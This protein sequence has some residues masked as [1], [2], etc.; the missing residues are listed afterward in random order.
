MT[1]TKKDKRKRRKAT[2]KGKKKLPVVSNLKRATPAH[3]LLERQAVGTLIKN[4]ATAGLPVNQIA[5]EQYNQL[6]N[7]RDVYARHRRPDQF[8]LAGNQARQTLRNMVQPS[9]GGGRRETNVP[10]VPAVEVGNDG[11][12]EAQRVD[13]DL[14]DDLRDAFYEAEGP[15]QPP[16]AEEASIFDPGS[17][18]PVAF[19]EQLTIDKTVSLLQ[20]PQALQ[21]MEEKPW[22]KNMTPEQQERYLTSLLQIRGGKQEEEKNDSVVEDD[23]GEEEKADDEIDDSFDEE[24]DDYDEPSVIKQ[25]ETPGVETP[26]FSPEPFSTTPKKTVTFSDIP[27]TRVFAEVSPFSSSSTSSPGD[28]RQSYRNDLQEKEDRLTQ[29]YLSEL[30]PNE[31][32]LAYVNTSLFGTPGGRTA[33][34]SEIQDL[35]NDMDD[36]PMDL[37][38][39]PDEEQQIYE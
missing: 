4:H 24:D 38:L 18:I 14:R 11:R 33:S 17:Q 23:Y 13:D 36:T 29:Q 37:N 30:D 39:L 1:T 8:E 25:S 6:W 21:V 22:V 16:I 5:Y 34:S 2:R 20:T 10:I 35:M 12:P 32:S 28:I 26:G 3:L 19:A 9:G 27:Y 7:A 15:R 31:V